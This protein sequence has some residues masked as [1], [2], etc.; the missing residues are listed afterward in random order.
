[1][2]GAC[3]YGARVGRSSAYRIGGQRSTLTP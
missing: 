3:I 2:P 1:L